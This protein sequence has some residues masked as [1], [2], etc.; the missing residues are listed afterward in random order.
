MSASAYP[1]GPAC[2]SQRRR[3]LGHALAVGG[4]LFAQTPPAQGAQTPRPPIPGSSAVTLARS[5]HIDIDT[6]GTRRRVF[7]ACPDTPP[8]ASGFPVLFVLDGNALFPLLAQQMHLLT[9]RPES[10]PFNPPLIVGLG[11]PGEA[12]YN[13][14][15]RAADYTLTRI[16]SGGIE[17]PGAAHFLDFITERVAPL[18]RTH[19][20]IDST[21]ITL[22]G[23]SYGGL[24]TL[25]ALFSQI[26]LFRHF[27]AASPSLWW[28]NGAIF[29]LRD[30]FLAK[31][32]KD[33]SLAPKHTL[34]ITAGGLEETGNPAL[35][36][37]A[38]RQAERRVVSTA[39]TLTESLQG[40][41]SLDATF[42]LLP[43]ADHGSVILP[44]STMALRRAANLSAETVT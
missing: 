3:F 14:D 32:D 2:L 38:R 24:F 9:A 1:A 31:V 33:P 36:P 8:P 37:R 39:R 29:P 27:V 11:Y 15:A 21:Q 20:H 26:S 10:E 41:D 28:G 30:R 19:L 16:E 44:T 17:K 5:W 7:I 12:P 34:I 43:R 13:Q 6:A 23:H 22:F 42:H 25:Y 35:T 18:L 40:M 4:A